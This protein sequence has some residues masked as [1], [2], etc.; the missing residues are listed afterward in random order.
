[1]E[2]EAMKMYLSD[3]PTAGGKTNQEPRLLGW[4]IQCY[5]YEAISSQAASSQ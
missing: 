5:V 1:M 4:E 3:L 2:M